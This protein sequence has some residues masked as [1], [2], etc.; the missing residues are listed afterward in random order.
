MQNFPVIT[1]VRAAETG[2]LIEGTLNSKPNSQFAIDFFAN[3]SCDFLGNGEGE[4]FIGS[5]TVT[6]N[7]SCIASFSAVLPVA[8]V[9]GQIITV[10]ATD[11]NNNTSEFSPCFPPSAVSGPKLSAVSIQ[12]KN[13]IV[14]GAGFDNGAVI[15]LNGEAQKTK[16]DEQDPEARLIGKKVGK[17]IAP[18]QTV[19][20]QV[21]N[22]NGSLSNQFIFTRIS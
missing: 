18:G 3:H 22:S 19:S 17:Q 21:R 8:I 5:I 7:S 9:P 11:S 12:G 20:V 1:A 16:K 10:T 6:T 13:L 14:V 2:T 15:L 4:T